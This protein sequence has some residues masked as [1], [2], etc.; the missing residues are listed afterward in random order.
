MIRYFMKAVLLG[1]LMISA[2]LAA[3]NPWDTRLPFKSATIKY[4][5]SGMQNG[6]ELLYIDAYGKKQARFVKSSGKVLFQTVQT[7]TVEITTEE[8]IYELDLSKKH[9]T[10]ITNPDIYF[11]EEYAKL[12]AKE[13]KMVNKNAE[14][15]G[16]NLMGGMG[17]NIEKNAATILGYK[18]DKMNALGTTVYMMHGATIALKT[19]SNLMGLSSKVIAQEI[20]KGAVPKSVFIPPKGI[21]ISFDQE[22]DALN[23]SMAQS[24][25]EMLK[26]PNAA[27]KMQ[28]QEKLLMSE[29]QPSQQQPDE[30]VEEGLKALKGLF[31]K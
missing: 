2:A 19:E 5:V 16:T 28:E 1:A 15:M 9:G 8:W 18:T 6:T 22:T 12:T 10:K 3:E 27:A 17:G 29:D 4:K 25:V 21:Q 23:R 7:D 31:G 13:K 14:K 11:K 20:K 30:S 24:T 26:D